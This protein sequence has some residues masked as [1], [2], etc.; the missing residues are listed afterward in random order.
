MRLE[1]VVAHEVA[2][3]LL[4]PFGLDGGDV[5]GVEAA[6]F[7]KLGGHHPFGF[8]FKQRGGGEQVEMCAARSGVVVAVGRFEA[9]VGNQAG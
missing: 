8:G 9:D 2:G 5:A 7:G 3:F 4:Y 6:G 1:I